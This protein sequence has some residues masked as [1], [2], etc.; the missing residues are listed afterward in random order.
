MARA[1]VSVSETGMSTSASSGRVTGASPEQAATRHC[2]GR[3]APRGDLL[4]LPFEQA[5]R[6]HAEGFPCPFEQRVERALA[7]QDGPGRG[8]EQLGLGVGARRLL[9]PAS[10]HV[11]NPA[12]HEPHG[13]EHAERERVVRLGDRELVQRRRE[14]VVQQQRRRDGLRHGGQEPAD[15]RDGD[16]RDEEREHIARQ[17]DARPVDGEPERHERCEHHGENPSGGLPLPG[18]SAAVAGEDAPAAAGVRVGDHVHVDSARVADSPRP[19]PRAGEHGEQPG[20]AAGADHQLRGVL[21]L[22]EREER[23]GDVVA[24]DLVVGAAERLHQL[25]LPGQVGRVGAGEPVGL[26]DVHGEQ[27]A[28]G[29]PGGD[30]R[31]PPDQRVA[32][33]AAGERDDDPFPRLPGG[34]DVVLVPV[35]LQSLVDLVG[36]PEQREF[37]QRGQVPGAEVVGERRVDLLRRVDVPVRHPAA[38]RLGSHVDKLDLVGGPHHGVGHGLP[39]R[40]PGDLLDH[41]GHRLEVLDVDRGDHVDA[42]VEQLG[43]VLP[44]LGVPR[45]WHVG[46]RELVDKRDLRLAGE[47]RVDVHLFPLAAP[48]GQ[49]L[50]GDNL[51][52]VEQRY[53]LRPLVRLGERDNHVRP[54]LRPA[55]PL[56]EQG[57]RLPD[58][59]S[60]PKVDPQLP[61]RH[62]AALAISG[63][64]SNSAATPQVPH[65]G[66]TT[67]MQ[68]SGTVR[69]R[70]LHP[71]PRPPPPAGSPSASLP[72][73]PLRPAGPPP[74][75]LLPLPSCRTGMIGS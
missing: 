1:S 61:P 18:D 8:H 58:S 25:P 11:H 50:A 64:T 43:D 4:V 32:L 28:A 47:H 73:T 74:S 57:E 48:V 34:G 36:Q 31:R 54:A 70:H 59:G 30:P 24:D 52:P 23:L 56:A 45:A 19:D 6:A 39:L 72:S 21:G 67:S 29:D 13:D 68:P 35:A 53:R 16:H 5:G 20:P 38:Q 46:V 40:H 10:R 65:A 27:V 3:P 49:L 42:R 41:V 22:R 69:F 62:D 2:S 44:A 9:G 66:L 12:H 60:G 33:G 26:G 51:K 17:V 75:S 63:H 14:V 71:I 7:A 55:V 37:A 15:D